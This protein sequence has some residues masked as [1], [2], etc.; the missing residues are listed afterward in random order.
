MSSY[1]D[2][3]NEAQRDAVE[4]LDGPAL[5]IAGAGSGKT[6]VLT[7]KIM[8]LLESG[9]KPYN[10]LAI[11][12]TNKAAR[13]MKE[14][15]AQKIGNDKAAQLWMGTFHSIFMKI[16]RMEVASTAYQKNFT[17]YDATDAK[18]VVKGIIKDMNLDDKLYDLRTVCSR[19]SSAKNDLITPEAYESSPQYADDSNA[20]RY[21]MVD[22]Y[23]SYVRKCVTSNAMD[24]DD[25]LLQ[26][27]NLFKNNPQLVDKYADKFR[28]ILVDEYQ[29]T[30]A[31]QYN[32]VKILASRHHK[33]FVVGDDAQSI[34]AFRGAKIENILNFR[35]DYK[36]ALLFKLEQNYR[37]TK[38]IVNAAN[39]VIAKNARQIKKDVYSENENGDK[40]RVLES[41]ADTEESYKIAAE[42]YSQV[43]NGDAQY[44]DFAL[45]YRSHSQSRS[46]EESLHKRQIPYKIFG[47][48]S[49]YERKEVKDLIAYLKLTLNGNDD[50]AFKRIVNYPKR[51]IGDTTMDKISAIATEKGLSIWN[52]VVRIT[53]FEPTISPRTINSLSLFMKMMYQMKIISE[54]SDAYKAALQI[55]T[56]SGVLKD[57]EAD[58]SQEGQGRYENVMELLNGVKQF[59]ETRQKDNGPASL[60][61]Y[62]E[63]V[64]L[65]T[66]DESDGDDTNKV[67]LLTIHAS[68]G[69][70]FKNVYLCGVEEGLFPS[71]KSAESNTQLEEER[72]LF[73]V[74]V[75]RAQKKLVI[76]YARMRFK[77]GQL[78]PAQPSRFIKEIDTKYLD[79]GA[80]GE[81]MFEA[82]RDI[83]FAG[84]FRKTFAENDRN[85]SYSPDSMQQS[86]TPR[87]GNF[88]KIST[89]SKFGSFAKVDISKYKEGVIVDH[90]KFGRGKVAIL[91]Q[92][93][94]DTKIVIDFPKVGRKT[95]LLK[96]ANANMKIVNQ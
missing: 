31:V 73:Y 30:N 52:T 42:I 21:K 40:I 89:A 79:F 92:S 82:S 7:Y 25:L 10:I 65:M 84:R 85:L 58:K 33:L 61:D 34:Y 23:R 90:D 75:T 50:E 59:V 68:K 43:H 88:K 60:S 38:V 86:S 1:L 96:Y 77:Y 36:E 55:A 51:G 80:G 45:L 6:R 24:F 49:F 62:L 12:F 16:L 37:S 70:E 35:R 87:F 91:D 47:G 48:L 72:R 41:S 2:E 20:K 3:L 54:S 46:L 13:E 4:Y 14:R 27:Y 18:N 32:I 83:P 29:D 66:G 71:P 44:S 94:S 93:G 95:L 15:I 78:A 19:I 69:L 76:S 5:V 17:I 28:Y 26:T 74:A 39:D 64:S 9:Y 56:T 63:E 11:T 53:E 57:L 22:I 67:S 8:H 81:S